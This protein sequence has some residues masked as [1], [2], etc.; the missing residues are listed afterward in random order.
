VV[1]YDAA[2][3]HSA[4]YTRALADAGVKYD[5]WDMKAS[6]TATIAKFVEYRRGTIVR[7]VNDRYQK[8]SQLNLNEVSDVMD[9]MGEGGSVLLIGQN[10]GEEFYGSPMMSYLKIDIQD[11]NNTARQLHG[12]NNDFITNGLTLSTGGDGAQNF[13]SCDVLIPY[14]N[15]EPILYYDAA[16]TMPAAMKLQTCSFRACYYG[17]GLEN[18]DGARNRSALLYKTLDWLQGNTMM[19]GV[20]AP[21][22]E[23]KMLDGTSTSF[24][25]EANLIA[26]D[27][28][29]VLEFFATWCSYCSELRPKLARIYSKYKKDIEIIAVSYNEKP[30][31]I[32]KYLEAYPE[33]SWNVYIDETGRGMQK[34]GVKGIPAI[35]V[36]DPAERRVRY[37]GANDS[38]E[39]MSAEI[40]KLIKSKE[41][42]V[43]FDKLNI[44]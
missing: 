25:N 2:D 15:V 21:S 33:V 12:V 17:F 26:K 8:E 13:A 28:I 4:F 18:I 31:K 34:Y 27:K 36:I 42:K 3:F 5:L 23:I 39:T 6:G 30:E 38:V 11:K 41:Q 44:K 7:I 14:D 43:K 29:V 35:F 22:F 9:F 37:I 10:M 16:K 32:K 24:L 40:E 19:V 1:L 20:E